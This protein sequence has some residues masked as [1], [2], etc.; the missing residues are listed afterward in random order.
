MPRVIQAGLIQGLVGRCRSFVMLTLQAQ[1]AKR[2][3]CTGHGRRVISGCVTSGL[4]DVR[5]CL[6]CEEA[7]CQQFIFCRIAGCAQL[8]LLLVGRLRYGSRESVVCCPSIRGACP[9]GCMGAKG[10]ER[11][12]SGRELRCFCS[13]TMHA[14]VTFMRAWM[15]P[16]A[17]DPLPTG[18]WRQCRD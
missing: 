13:S 14:S 5:V 1:V 11:V 10:I 3:E 7:T 17:T 18:S 8:P 9:Y 15:Q 16:F 6:S 4:K 2:V 12:C